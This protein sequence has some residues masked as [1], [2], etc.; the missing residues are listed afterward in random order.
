MQNYTIAMQCLV[1]LNE[2][3]PISPP[4]LYVFVS[5]SIA[6]SFYLRRRDCDLQQ[7]VVYSV[8]QLTIAVKMKEYTKHIPHCDKFMKVPYLYIHGQ[9][10]SGKNENTKKITSCILLHTFGQCTRSRLFPVFLFHRVRFAFVC[11]HHVKLKQK[12]VG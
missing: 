9:T 4:L 8:A 1:A 2:F 10:K 6:F 12:I 5:I 11:E 3:A 7:T